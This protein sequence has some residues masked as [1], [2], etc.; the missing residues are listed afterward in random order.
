MTQNKEANL[1]IY[2]HRKLAGNKDKYRVFK[3]APPLNFI[4]ACNFLATELKFGGQKEERS[5][6][7]NDYYYTTS[8]VVQDKHDAPIHQIGRTVVV[9]CSNSSDSSRYRS[10]I[11]TNI[12]KEEAIIK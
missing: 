1:F 7:E 9:I 3:N 11:C 4:S 12:I 8:V 5:L 10:P 2:V 6:G